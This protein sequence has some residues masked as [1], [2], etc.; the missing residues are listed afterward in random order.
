MWKKLGWLGEKL[1]FGFGALFT[2]IV[3]VQAALTACKGGA[4]GLLALVGLALAGAATVAGLRF[5]EPHRAFPAALFSLR[6]L[7]ALG[8]ILVFGAQPVQ[9][10]QT[11]Y[12]AAC[13]MAQGSR[14][15][16]H[17][18]YFYNWAYQT[19]FVAYEAL[20][21]RLFGE[22]LLPL[23]ICNA[24]WMAGTGCLVYAIAKRLLPEN[25]AMTVSLVY[26]LYPAPYFLAAVLTNQHIAAFFCYLG[27]WL[28]VRKNK[29]TLPWAALAGLCLSLG[30]V[31]RPL[32]AVIVLALLCW[33]VVRMC[34]WRGP[35]TLRAGGLLLAAAV[36]YFISTEFF[37][38][39][40]QATGLNP[41]GLSNNLPLWKFV[42]G[43]N[44][45]SGGAWNQ[46]DYNAYYLLP[47]EE[48]GEQMSQAVSQRLS[49]LGVGGFLELFWKK[50]VTMWGSL[51]YLY[52]GFGH[53]NGDAQ[54]LGSLTLSQCLSLLNYLNQ[55]VFL[56]AFGLA[57]TALVFWLWKGCGKGL[58]LP[59][60]LGFLLCGYYSVH[61]L[62]EVQARYRYFLMP[63]VFLLA[64]AG[65]QLLWR[66]WK[67]G[68]WPAP[69][70][71]G[72][73]KEKIP[74]T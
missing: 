49:S 38:W 7:I 15:Y 4:W 54:V 2:L 59:V 26:A 45:E 43:F 47:R 29:L 16:L 70:T 55:G 48:A 13:Q 3:I 9:D 11:M 17:N 60:M 24:L 19:G 56:G 53:L 30:N 69:E 39:L 8:V 58:R 25:G 73:K 52:W 34:S 40:V 27:F 44:L 5:L 31:M 46:A 28:L 67:E 33:V 64:G 36:V 6:F 72:R 14:E 42:L 32:G 22:S 21:I 50:S 65:A 62:I 12:G 41:E 63:A 61:L 35:G 74:L 66:R 51:E 71:L 68:A 18:D 10:F 37:S 1:C 23:Q 20:V 57:G